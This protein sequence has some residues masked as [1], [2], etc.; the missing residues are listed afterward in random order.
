[1]A[2]VKP[3]VAITAFATEVKGELVVVHEG[4]EYPSTH[5]VV[6]AN[7]EAFEAR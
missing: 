1:M 7:P 3:L 4:D 6:K 2:A 5:P